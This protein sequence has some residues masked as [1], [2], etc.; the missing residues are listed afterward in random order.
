MNEALVT[1]DQTR[2]YVYKDHDGRFP[3]QKEKAFVFRDKALGFIL[4]SSGM[5]NLRP[6]W[7]V[8]TA[9]SWLST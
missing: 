8:D 9:H 6:I 4:H 7:C 3:A 2:F 1:N 5:S